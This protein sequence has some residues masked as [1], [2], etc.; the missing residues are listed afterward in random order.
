MFEVIRKRKRSWRSAEKYGWVT[1]PIP[2]CNDMNVQLEMDKDLQSC[3]ARSAWIIV[4]AMDAF[5]TLEDDKNPFGLTFKPIC[6][7]LHAT[8]LLT[9]Q[10]CS[11]KVSSLQN[12]FFSPT[13]ILHIYVA[14]MERKYVQCIFMSL[15]WM[16]V[17]F[18]FDKGNHIKNKIIFK[19]KK[20]KVET[21]I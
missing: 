6:C 10:T 17:S 11:L 19:K 14:Y 16:K 8:R 5:A 15:N 12:A 7:L 3:L 20:M 18:L 9:L 4:W 1:D 2:W 21:S 13:M